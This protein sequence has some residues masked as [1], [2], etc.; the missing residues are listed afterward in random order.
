MLRNRSLVLVLTA[1]A[2]CGGA[3]GCADEG[4][5]L[6]P[7]SGSQR[8][9][10]IRAQTCDELL[11]GLQQDA[12]AKAEFAAEQVKDG[13]GYGVAV[14]E[15]AFGGVAEDTSSAAPTA[16]A[17]NAR[18]AESA[19]TRFSETNNQ[20]AGVDE[21]DIVKTDGNQMYLLHGTE[22]LVFRS[23]PADALDLVRTIDIEGS[24]HEMFVHDQKAVVVSSVIDADGKF[25]EAPE[26][27]G[28]IGQPEPLP[29]PAPDIAGS[30]RPAYW[31]GR[32]FTKITVLNTENGRIEREAYMEGSYTS[33]RRHDTAVRTVIQSHLRTPR[34]IPDIYATVWNGS[35]EL[36]DVERGRRVDAWLVDAKNA[37]RETSLDDWMVSH[38]ERKGDE[39]VEHSV[40][41]SDFY[42]PEPGLTENG[43]THVAAL[44]MNDAD[45]RLETTSVL[46]QASEI[47][48]NKDVMLIAH[49]DWS[50]MWRGADHNQTTLHRFA[51]GE[52]SAEGPSAAT[53]YT[54]SGEV[55]GTIEDQFSL[56]ER[57]G[58]IRV[59]TTE[60]RAFDTT[61]G[62]TIAIGPGVPNTANYVTTLEEKDGALVQLGQTEALAKG[63]R[64]FSARYI[65]DIAYVVTFRQVDPLFAI[66]LSNPA[67]PRVLGELKIPG[68]S[69]YMHPLGDDH[70]LTIGRDVDERT[71]RD[72]GLALQIFDVSDPTNPVQ[73]HKHLVAPDA[74]SEANHEHKAFTYYADLKLL[75]F[76]VVRYG[77]DFQS[78]L[79]LFSVDT[80]QGF[81]RRGAIAHTD[82]LMNT[83]DNFVEWSCRQTAPTVRRGLFIDDYVYSISFG[84]VL[85]HSVDSM[86]E[87]ARVALEQ[88]KWTELYR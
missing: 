41:C 70:L 46:G 59:A 18:Q 71:Q 24:P 72:N 60:Q 81:E 69:D 49:N 7:Y 11:S 40:S 84:G 21:A 23:W 33:A 86:D 48:A 57:D 64:I 28:G 35:G 17:S 36:S 54:G 52:L 30:S 37:I 1:F 47:Y 62:D 25:G 44:D 45:A 74:Y 14:A 12:I 32:A 51:L 34:E 9:A 20:V 77:R 27:D 29:S 13:G 80:E 10:L 19:P 16:G 88:P 67:Q 78:T 43:I 2:L 4:E 63:E 68:F 85:V 56:D 61:T 5:T 53:R 87:V 42:L 15:P 76:P 22:L 38:Y 66:D 3:L 50:W 65:G 79:D 31:C 55:R 83:C 75:A 39:I 26:C 8:G 6:P 58:V 82:L 73:K